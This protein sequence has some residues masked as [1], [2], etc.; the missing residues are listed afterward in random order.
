M[1]NPT[2][3]AATT[4]PV[5]GWSRD[6]FLGARASAVRS[7]YSPDYI[8]VVGPHAPRRLAI[9]ALATEDMSDP[10]ALP[11]AFAAARSGLRL[12]LSRRVAPMPYVLRNVEC[13]EIH[14]IQEGEIEFRTDFGIMTGLPGDFVCIPRSVAYRATP[15]AGQVLDLIVESP[16]A[17]YFDTP[18][19]AGMIHFGNHV[20]HASPEA[21]SAADAP[22][23]L[24]LRGGDDV[25]RFEKAHDPLSIQRHLSGL[26]PVWKLNLAHIQPVVYWP[27]GGPPS[28][29]LASPGNEVLFYTLSARPGPRPPVHVNAD[30]DE[31][32]HY[33][34]GPDPWGA[35]DE[36]GTW[37]WVP[38]GVPHQGP[39]EHVPTGYLAWLLET[40]STLR[41]TDLGARASEPMETGLYG[42]HDGARV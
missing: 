35:V 24:L 37:T 28:H 18:S 15:R 16:G 2:K 9:G 32:I 27:H 5:E 21:G 34:R 38:K 8:S 33:F 20:I 19:P 39:P 25:T 4:A 6:G 36:P 14:F 7:H 1:S 22:T 11:S 42:R 26:S 17:V 23:T 40:R 30:Y 31:V 29:F 13:D 41:L 3:G 12:S 10:W